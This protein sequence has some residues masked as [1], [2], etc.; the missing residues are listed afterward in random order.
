MP[1]NKKPKTKCPRARLQWTE[2]DGWCWHGGEFANIYHWIDSFTPK[3]DG[4]P[5][6]PWTDH[7]GKWVPVRLEQVV[8][9]RGK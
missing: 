2:F 4:K 3:N 8:P 9:G 6:E 7:G 1:K 5:Q